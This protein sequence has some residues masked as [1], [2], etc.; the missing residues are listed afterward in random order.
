MVRKI[1]KTNIIDFHS[2]AESRFLK[3]GHEAQQVRG[4]AIWVE[5]GA[6]WRK[7]KS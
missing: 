2:Y 4:V 6:S 1:G 3:I 7:G 5:E